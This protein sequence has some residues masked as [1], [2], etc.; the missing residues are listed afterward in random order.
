MELLASSPEFN[1]REGVVVLRGNS[2]LRKRDHLSGAQLVH[3]LPAIMQAHAA[4]GGT[5]AV[6]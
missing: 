6:T 1:W 3:C 4:L 2:W 5:A